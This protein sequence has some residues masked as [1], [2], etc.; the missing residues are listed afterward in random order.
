LVFKSYIGKSK[1]LNAKDGKNDHSTIIYSL[2]FNIIKYKYQQKK[3]IL[4]F[5]TDFLAVCPRCGARGPARP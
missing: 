1:F 3:C 2:F 5:F 4:I